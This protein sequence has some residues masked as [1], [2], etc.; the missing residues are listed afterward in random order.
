M[1]LNLIRFCLLDHSSMSVQSKIEF[2]VNDRFQ[3]S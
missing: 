1:L 2:E 3:T